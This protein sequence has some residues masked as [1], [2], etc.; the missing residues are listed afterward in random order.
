M[1]KW[2]ILGIVLVLLMITPSYLFVMGD[3]D[4]NDDMEHAEV[5]QVGEMYYGHLNDSDSV[6]YYKVAVHPG[7]GV[8]VTLTCDKSSAAY[9]AVS[10]RVLDS[11]GKAIKSPSGGPLEIVSHCVVNSGSHLYIE[12]YEYALQGYDD[13]GSNT[14]M[15]P[16]SYTL[17]VEIKNV[18]S[19]PKNLEVSYVDSNKI[20]LRWDRPD[21]DGGTGIANT[22]D[23]TGVYYRI[24]RDGKNIDNVY[25]PY[26]GGYAP[27][28]YT[29]TIEIHG[30]HPAPQRGQNYSWYVTAVNWVGE[31]EPSNTVHAGLKEI[32][33]S[34]STSEPSSNTNTGDMVCG[35]IILLAIIGAVLFLYRKKRKNNP[36]TQP[37]ALYNQASQDNQY[38]AQPPYNSQYGQQVPQA[39][40]ENQQ[41]P[42]QQPPQE[43]PQQPPMGDQYPPQPPSNNNYP[44]ERP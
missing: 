25:C 15:K 40:P 26:G 10:Y 43:P 4:S 35:S 23:Y 22:G 41:Y 12:V 19:A 32:K 30:D 11:T 31:S 33:S 13:Y 37:Y 44:P 42:P 14:K 29:N 9:G 27:T 8:I 18:P 34:T 5:I 17:S 38:P 2:K 1:R 7:D 20:T 3:T 24:Y 36:P 6:D 39:P 21:D 28:T 16:R